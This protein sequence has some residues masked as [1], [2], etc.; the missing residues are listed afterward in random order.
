MNRSVYHRAIHIL[1][2]LLI[3]VVSC[4]SSLIPTASPVFAIPS[5]TA[6]AWGPNGSGQ[7]GNNTTNWADT[8]V[9]VSGLTGVVSVAAGQNFSLAAKSNG[10]VW[11]WGY[12][13]AGRLGDG[14][15][16]DSLIPV[17]VIGLSGT[18][19]VSAGSD[20]SMALKSDGTVWAWGSNDYGQLGNGTTSS[21]NTSFPVQV[22]D[23]AGTGNLTGVTA[24]AGG[25]WYYSLALVSGGT[26]WAWGNNDYGTI[27]DGTQW[28]NRL[29]PVQVKDAAGTGTLTGITAISAGF[30]HNLALKSDGTVWAWGLN[31]LGQLGDNKIASSPSLLPIQVKDTAGTGNLTGITAIAAGYQHNLAVKADGTVWAWGSNTDGELGD[32]TTIERDLPVQVIGLTGVAAVAAGANYS[33]AIKSDGTVWQWG[34]NANHGT[35]T[36]LPVQVSGLSEAIAI[37]TKY[38]HSLVI[39]STALSSNANLGN[40]SISSGTLTPAFASGTI[41]YTDSVAYAVTS[42]TVTPTVSESHATVTVNGTTVASG[43]PSSAISLSVGDTAITIVVTAQDTTTTKTYTVTVTRSVPSTD[44]NLSNLTISSGTPTPAFA[45]GTINYTDSVA[46][47]VTSITV[48]PTVSESHATVKVNT[49]TV[50]SGSPSGAI[51][52]SVGANTITVVVTAQDTTTTKTYTVTV[53][54]AVPSTDANL[55]NLTISSGTLTPAFA[56]GTISYTDNVTNAVTSFTVTPTV[57]ESH[58]T[59]KVNTVTVASGAPSGA[60][61]LSVGANAITV[62]ITAQDTT[63]TKTYTVTV[64]RAAAPPPP[65]DGGGGGGG[66]IMDVSLIGLN[67]SLPI[68][69]PD[70]ITVQAAQLV[71]QDKVVTLSV[72]RL[73][74]LVNNLGNPITSISVTAVSP[75][76]ASPPERFI[77]SDYNFGPTGATFSPALTITMSYDPKKLPQGASESELYIAYWDGSQWIALTSTVNTNAHTVSAAITHFSNYA[78]MSKLAPA[79]GP[80]PIPAQVPTPPVITLPT[81]TPL[82]TPAPVPTQAPTQTP[83]P[84]PVQTLTPAPTQTPVPASALPVTLAP[85]SSTNW[86]LIWWII[87][88]AILA[89]LIIF[90]LVRSFIWGRKGM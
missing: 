44:A 63:T 20:F 45:S 85:T 5:E 47:A 10:T 76:P 38:Y 74:K 14:T 37:S 50:A 84:A 31:N 51:S 59:I 62:V 36:R 87:G 86:G 70:G 28:V 82:I 9:Q 22:K 55:S 49:V 53:T 42:V 56:S 90:F 48:T 78:L 88:G 61:S 33:V 58:A 18:T 66:G 13:G 43:S 30:G 23:A 57:N 46:N 15:Q 1:I 11:A 64:T 16:T 35:A 3:L 21:G 54:R 67:G 24:L 83:P 7:L 52:L 73:A 2:T 79:P 75:L 71:S 89:I 69:I 41:S 12:N 60:I 6:W 19:N 32:N 29:L 17:Q 39:M 72:P 34:Y 4:F 77:L 25:D 80:T 40:L 81:T 65:S 68:I 26:V 27:G 8:P